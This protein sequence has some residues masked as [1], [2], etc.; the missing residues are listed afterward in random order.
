MKSQDLVKRKRA[1]VGT[2]DLSVLRKGGII[3][4]DTPHRAENSISIAHFRSLPG[5]AC[6]AEEAW[7][8]SI[9]W[10]DDI[11]KPQIYCPPAWAG[12][13]SEMVLRTETKQETKMMA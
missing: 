5:G 10:L 1:L 3:L 12:I 9:Q 2:Y 8:K 11:M 13:L 4:G 6:V 7:A